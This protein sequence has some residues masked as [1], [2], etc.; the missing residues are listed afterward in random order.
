MMLCECEHGSH[1]DQPLS[2]EPVTIVD[3]GHDFGDRIPAVMGVVL[4]TVRGQDSTICDLCVYA[5]H[6]GSPTA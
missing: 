4:V 5:G 1:G 6:D 3:A 2:A